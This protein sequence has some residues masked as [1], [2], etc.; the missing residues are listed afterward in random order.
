[1]RVPRESAKAGPTSCVGGPVRGWQRS[2]SDLEGSVAGMQSCYTDVER[3]I[4]PLVV[5]EFVGILPPVLQGLQPG[6]L[7]L[8]ASSRTN[9]NSFKYSTAVRCKVAF[10]QQEK[11]STSQLSSNLYCSSR[12]WRCARM[13]SFRPVFYSSVQC[14]VHVHKLLSFPWNQHD[15]HTCRTD[16]LVNKRQCNAGTAKQKGR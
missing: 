4:R 13:K 10:E 3:T 8:L 5:T 14:M 15:K 7:W 6:A 12:S 9:S 2:I 16:K 11:L 1:M